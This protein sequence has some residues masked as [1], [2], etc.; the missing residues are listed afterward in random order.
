MNHRSII[1]IGTRH[2]YQYGVGAKWGKV[3][4]TEAEE[5]AFRE[6]VR[7]VVV[8]SGARGIGEELNREA[9][10]EVG[11]SVSVLQSVASELRLP[12]LFCE[13][14]RAER[15]QLGVEQ[16]ND[17]RI[18]VFLSDGEESEVQERLRVQFRKREQDWLR[19]L[20]AFDHCP[21]L[22][23]CGANHVPSFSELLRE[24]GIA[25]EVVDSDWAA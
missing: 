1:L 11:K 9:L 14:S 23:V 8:K 6:F 10:A 4:C 20:L 2:T 24:A 18:G 12:H 13:P 21:V 15:A 7:S 5:Q 3:P 17:I 19:R 25:C 16:E 22:Y